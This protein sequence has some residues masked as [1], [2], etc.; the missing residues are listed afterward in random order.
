LSITV[1]NVT[2]TLIGGSVNDPPVLLNVTGP[3]SVVL[4]VEEDNWKTIVSMTSLYPENTSF[5]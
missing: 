4:M 1:V 3:E 5:A 2:A